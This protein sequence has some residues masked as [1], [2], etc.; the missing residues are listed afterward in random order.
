MTK[1]IRRH[2]TK[3]FKLEAV[4]LLNEQ[5]YSVAE[6]ANNLGIAVSTLKRWRKEFSSDGDDAFPGKGHMTAEK[7]ELA[8]LR[9]QV[10]R[11]R[12]ERDILKKATA[13]FAK[14]QL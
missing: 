11:L 1:R 14:D 5:D 8:R 10:K 9:K 2:F 3:E 12:M 4:R 13:F 6:A 7:E